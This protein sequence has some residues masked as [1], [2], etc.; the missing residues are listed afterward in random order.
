MNNTTRIGLFAVY[1]ILFEYA[2][3]ILTYR[4]NP[5]KV[6]KRIWRK[7]QKNLAVF[8]QYAKIHKN[9]A[10]LGEFFLSKPKIFLIFYLIHR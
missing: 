2:E 3:S 6:L 5:Q 10:Y 8:S 9:L 4:E 1:K 7:R